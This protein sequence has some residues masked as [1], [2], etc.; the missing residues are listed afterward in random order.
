MPEAQAKA[1]PRMIEDGDDDDVELSMIEETL[2]T[3]SN[4]HN[5]GNNKMGAASCITNYSRCQC[6]LHN[7]YDTIE[8]FLNCSYTRGCL[9]GNTAAAATRRRVALTVGDKLAATYLLRERRGEPRK[10]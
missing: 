8:S 6:R 2:R 5:N 9:E 10:A 4:K 3:H 7:V 1:G